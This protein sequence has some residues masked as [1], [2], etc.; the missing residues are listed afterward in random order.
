MSD[1]NEKPMKKLINSVFEMYRLTDKMEQVSLV[2]NWPDIVGEGISRK[3]NKVYTKDG[4]LFIY[5]ES[6]ALKN[7]LYFHRDVIR[8][9]C[10]SYIGKDLIRE[11]VIR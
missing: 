10:N 7:E 3:T 5:L 4:K 6:A 9:K 11:V 8:E 2:R 1:S